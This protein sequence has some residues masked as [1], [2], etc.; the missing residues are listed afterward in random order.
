MTS[1]RHPL[2]S[3]VAALAGA[4]LVT[5][6]SAVVPAAT[7]VF[8]DDGYSHPV[9]PPKCTTEQ[10][11]SGDVGD[12]LLAFYNDPAADG[13]GDAPEP[14]VGEGWVWD[15]H[16]YRGSPALADFEA[17]NITAN[18]ERVGD[19]RVGYLSTNTL[20]HQLF[21]GFLAEIQAKGYEVRHVSG[22]SFRCTGDWDCSSGG[23]D[24]LSL[25]AWGLA[26]DMNSDANPIRTYPTCA[27]E[28]ATDLPE[29]AI[30]TAERWGL[31][32]GGY[33]WN[34]GCNESGS[35][36][37][38][39]TRDAPHF[40]YRGTPA[41]ARAIA[42]FNYGN[43]P[44]LRCVVTVGA[45]GDDVQQCNL[46]GTPDAGWRLAV[47][48]LDT[49][50]PEGA[51]AALVNVTA[52]GADQAGFLT[53]ESCAAGAD[54]PPATSTLA[55]LPG[56]TVATL[57]IAELDADGRFC[58]YRY[59][60]VHSVV[61]VVGY[62]V[63]A[64]ADAPP[65]PDDPADNP[66]DPEPSDPDAPADPAWLTPITPQRLLDTRTG[67]GAVDDDE[68][69]I[70]G[71]DGD[72]LVNL[73]AVAEGAAGFLQ[74]GA[75]GTLGADTEFSNVNYLGEAVPG[76]VSLRS[77]LTLVRGAD[78]ACVYSYAEADVVVDALGRLDDSPEG[79]GWRVTPARRALDTR[80]DSDAW[81]HGRP[82]AGTLIPLDLSGMIADDTAAVAVAITV[83]QPAAAGFITVGT[84]AELSRQLAA[85][86]SPTTSN[87]NHLAGQNVTN[88]AVVGLD[89]GEMC[90]Y[91]LAAAHV[92]IDVQAELTD[93][94]TVGLVAVVPH[95]LH[96]SRQP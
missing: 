60:A 54:G 36:N 14:G 31:Y 28:V 51:V 74:A 53:I 10:A 8:A 71:A 64:P 87:L 18:T 81:S 27:D 55:Y 48:A 65:E 86:G 37:S 63:E 20:A 91:T 23:Y 34:R 49:D 95:R 57:A 80:D 82:T 92:V 25:H 58:V 85:D 38:S 76:G 66:D 72:L 93:E 67:S 30:R 5:A 89:A 4:A 41:Q 40:E 12:C 44:D 9:P 68:R 7:V 56:D 2:V 22:Y 83:T 39:V 84:C 47:D 16:T 3:R 70:P 15:G 19:L 96:D 26:I 62:L 75:C 29:W 1:L 50:A 11:D 77:N 32:W 17:A 13:F 79:L 35:T 73:A 52:T 88:L 33:G 69:E 45:D 43:N 94:H 61:D 21:E 46:S 42:Q 78:A 6:V 24:D 59:S 90:V